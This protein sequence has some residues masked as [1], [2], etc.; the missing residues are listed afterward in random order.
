MSYRRPADLVREKTEPDPKIH[1]ER[2]ERAARLDE[3]REEA[4]FEEVDKDEKQEE[5]TS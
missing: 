5:K 3:E 2:Q 1:E 4:F